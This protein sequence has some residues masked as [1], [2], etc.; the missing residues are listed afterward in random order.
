MRTNWES[1]QPAWLSESIVTQPAVKPHAALVAE[2]TSDALK[3]HQGLQLFHLRTLVIFMRFCNW[4][5]AVGIRHFVKRN[6]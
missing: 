6:Y 3:R 2:D 1:S 4:V 5:S